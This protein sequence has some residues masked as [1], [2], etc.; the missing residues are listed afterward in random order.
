MHCMAS[1]VDPVVILNLGSEGLCLGLRQ[2]INPAEDLALLIVPDADLHI[3]QS[4]L[5]LH[6]ST[7]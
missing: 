3:Q 5:V 6:I 1:H 4:I 2:A 7:R